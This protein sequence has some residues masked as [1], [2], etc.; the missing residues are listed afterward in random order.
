MRHE[1]CPLHATALRHPEAAAV[2]GPSG[3]VV[4]YNACDKQAQAVA[5]A[6]RSAG[7]EAGSR[8]AFPGQADITSLPILF[9]AFRAGVAVYCPNTRLPEAALREQIARVG[10]SR[11]IGDD[12]FGDSI[13]RLDPEALVGHSPDERPAEVCVDA[14]A[15]ILATSGSTG[16]PKMAVHSLANHVANAEASNRNIALGPGDRWLLSLPLYHVSGLGI[17]FR[18]VM[19]GATVALRDP[20]EPLEESVARL[21]VTHL[22]LVAA[23]LR[24][25]LETDAGRTVLSR[26]KAVLLGG[27]AIP[28]SLVQEAA[29]CHV[30]LHTTYG[31]TETASQVTTTPPGACLDVLKTSGRPL[32]PAS[33]R[34][35][36]DKELEV[37]GRTLFLGYLEEDGLM[38]RPVTPDG[39]FP[40][41]D[42]G[43]FDACGNLMVTGRKD[44]MFVSGGENIQPEEIEAALCALEEVARAV[45]VPVGD[46]VFGQRPLAFVETASGFD[47]APERLET[48]LE[49]VLPRYKRPVAYLGWPE[50]MPEGGIKADRRFLQELAVRQ[51]RKPG[52]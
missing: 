24:R 26:L 46:P 8:V 32:L 18:C 21:H 3:E 9:G 31:L 36:E 37:S 12:G 22:S 11:I 1:S 52:R 15:T 4:T 27:S 34:V 20:G 45:V 28:A 6:L 13:P 39:W 25:L 7:I 30:P 5:T 10:C 17:V 41:G 50:S 51:A 35:V 19:G 38:H 48:Y 29:A 33:I 40:T 2:A 14:P 49:T 47:L 16:T 23:Q 42:L 44:N 43:Y